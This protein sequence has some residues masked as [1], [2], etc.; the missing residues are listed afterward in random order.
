LLK[1]LATQ[2]GVAIHQ[3]EL[4]Q[5]LQ[6]ANQKLEAL[7]IQDGLTQIANRRW[8]DETLDRQWQRLQRE[9]Q[10]LSLI[11]CDIDEF[12]PYN[13]YY[14]HQQGDHCLVEIA[15][16]LQGVVHR[17]D[18]LAARY[19][20]EEFA[21]ILPNTSAD[22]ALIVA[23]RAREAVAQ[24]QIPH[25]PSSVAPHVTLTLGV[26]TLIPGTDHSRKELIRRADQALYQ[27]KA[28]GRDRAI[29][30]VDEPKSNL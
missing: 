8:F 6:Q 29:K 10:P 7:A 28:Q 19:G 30:F 21:L 18:D 15:K 12:K 2:V 5:Q 13:D 20:G 23:E 16:A 9:Q 4:Y 11:L 24:L 3:A 25:D 27:A 26:G 14:G 22:N 17:P 1:Q